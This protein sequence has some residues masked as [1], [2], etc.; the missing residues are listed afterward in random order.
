MSFSYDL[1]RL[2]FFHRGTYNASTQYELNDV[3][4]YGGQSYVYVNLVKASGNLPTATTHWALL[5]GGQAYRGVWA[6][7][8]TYYPNDLVTHG[9]TTYIVLLFHT[10]TT[11]EADLNAN[12]LNEFAEGF[13]WRGDWVTGTSYLKGDVVSDGVNTLIYLEDHES[14]ATVQADIDA[15]KLEQLVAGADYLPSQAGNSGKILTTDGTNPS[16]TDDVTLDT[17]TVDELTIQTLPLIAGSGASTLSANLTNPINVHVTNTDTTYSDPAV[18]GSFAQFAIQNQATVGEG[19]STDFIAMADVGTDSDGWIDMGI[20]GT[21]FDDTTYGITGPHDGYIFMVAPEGTTGT[22]NLV[23]ATGDTG[24]ENKIVFAAGGLTS[25]TEQMI[26]VPNDFVH[27]EIATPSTSPTTGA[28]RVVGGVGISGNL[29]VLGN[30]NIQGTITIGGGAFQSDNLT[31]SDPLIFSGND[32]PADNFDL[33]YIGEYSEDIADIGP[34][35]ITDRA[36]TA[37]TAVITTAAPHGFLVG[38]TVTITGIGAGFDAANARIT[39]IDSILEF[40][41]ANTGNTVAEGA[42]PGGAEATVTR[43]RKFFGMVRDADTNHI[44]LFDGVIGLPTT[45]VDFTGASDMAIRMGAIT[46]PS[47]NRVQMASDLNTAPFSS[48]PA[49]ATAYVVDEGRYYE[50]RASGW[51]KAISGDNDQVVIGG[52][53]FG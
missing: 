35:T 13:R 39:G 33:G 6:T 42:A 49:G 50:K 46:A 8:Q 47:L 1:G 18:Q 14:G 22:G 26:I 24:T 45:T 21:N 51:S 38:D 16:W 53:L 28:F 27:V 12:K 34:F 7:G 5:S 37:N 29:N 30:T 3:V 48:Y 32:N 10:S 43:R 41:Y 4:S 20:T 17:V 15:S 44:R 25:G 40:T 11:H 31:V 2:R 9:G 52:R 36:R 23:L 19:S